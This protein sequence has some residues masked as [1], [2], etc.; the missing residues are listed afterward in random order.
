MMYRYVI[1]STSN[2]A[3]NILVFTPGS[4]SFVS[5]RPD[6]CIL[7]AS[8]SELPAAWTHEMAPNVLWGTHRLTGCDGK[9]GPSRRE[10]SPVSGRE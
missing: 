2:A 4:S 3:V 1:M 10:Q 9:R 5:F 8:H 6:A 7:Q